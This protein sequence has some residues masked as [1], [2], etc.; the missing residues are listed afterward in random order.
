MWYIGPIILVT[1]PIASGITFG[2]ISNKRVFILGLLLLLIGKV[3]PLPILVWWIV[4]GR[5]NNQ[6]SFM[7]ND[8]VVLHPT[9]NSPKQAELHKMTVTKACPD[10]DLKIKLAVRMDKPQNMK[11]CG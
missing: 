11:A 2:W 10:Q 5:I 8:K 7:S 9:P 4:I 3:L 1:S 6:G